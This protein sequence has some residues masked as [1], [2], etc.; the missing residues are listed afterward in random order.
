MSATSAPQQLQL[1]SFGSEAHSTCSD[2]TGAFDADESSSCVLAWSESGFLEAANLSTDTSLLDDDEVDAASTADS[3]FSAEL[4]DDAIEYIWTD[5]Y[6]VAE[7]LEITTKDSP[8]A[9]FQG[10]NMAPMVSVVWASCKVSSSW[11]GCN[12]PIS[13]PCHSG[14]GPKRSEWNTAEEA[15]ANWHCFNPEQPQTSRKFV[16]RKRGTT[17]LQVKLPG[18]PARL[19]VRDSYLVVPDPLPQPREVQSDVDAGADTDT[20]ADRRSIAGEISDDGHDVTMAGSTHAGADMQEQEEAV[21]VV[22]SAHWPPR[23]WQD[24]VPRNRHA[25]SVAHSKRQPCWPPA[26]VQAASYPMPA[27]YPYPQSIAPWEQCLQGPPSIGLYP[28]GRDSLS[29]AIY[30]DLHEGYACPAIV[31]AFTATTATTSITGSMTSAMS[32]STITPMTTPT[33]TS[34]SAYASNE[35]APGTLPTLDTWAE[36][37][38]DLLRAAADFGLALATDDVREG[39][40]STAPLTRSLVASEIRW[41]IWNFR[42]WL[43][44]LR[45][46][47][48]GVSAKRTAIGGPLAGPDKW[49]TNMHVAPDWVTGRPVGLG[50][51]KVEQWHTMRRFV[52]TKIAGRLHAVGH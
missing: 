49:Y 12:M 8:V 24:F 36:L 19:R 2:L 4:D 6:P 13:V 25:S 35:G 32:T 31:P 41:E 42:R 17:P 39:M 50:L 27:S 52:P 16:I 18:M 40:P 22:K 23:Q 11:P 48:G 51:G 43:E 33:P 37:C 28:A 29:A 26:S 9:L 45:G 15:I 5:D 14:C 20:D 38:K 7:V 10:G 30:W 47:A 3:F 34:V 46:L 21:Q 1:D 44:S